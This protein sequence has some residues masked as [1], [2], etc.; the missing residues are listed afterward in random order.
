MAGTCFERGLE[1]PIPEADLNN[2]GIGAMISGVDVDGDGMLEIYL[3]ND[4]WND[5]ATEIIPL[6]VN[7]KPGTGHLFPQP[8]HKTFADRSI[9]FWHNNTKL[10]AAVTRDDIGVARGAGHHLREVTQDL[11]PDRMT[12]GVV[13]GLEIVDVDDDHSHG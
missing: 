11:I 4:N 7:G 8:G 10:I 6:I 13:D 3:V 9:G 12:I 2:G 5:G 1:I